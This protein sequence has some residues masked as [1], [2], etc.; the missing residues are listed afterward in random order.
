M[1]ALNNGRY[2]QFSEDINNIV[3]S[4]RHIVV[5]IFEDDAETTFAVDSNSNVIDKKTI[6][7]ISYCYP[8]VDEETGVN[9]NGSLTINFL[10]DSNIQIYDDERNLW[11]R[12]ENI[13]TA[14]TP[15]K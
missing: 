15:L 5:S 7:G 2:T 10:D 14:A 12:L 13:S 3:M 1:N 9:V 4:A 11:Y 6:N 8:S